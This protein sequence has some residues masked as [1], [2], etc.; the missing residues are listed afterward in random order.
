MMLSELT[1]GRAAL[2]PIGRVNERRFDWKF[3]RVRD[4]DFLPI[5]ETRYPAP[6]DAR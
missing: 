3:S 1:R 2:G 5:K 6:H 4:T